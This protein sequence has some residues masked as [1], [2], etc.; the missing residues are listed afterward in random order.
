[1]AVDRSK[2]LSDVMERVLNGVNRPDETPHT[3]VI[4]LDLR[5]WLAGT[6]VTA[7]QLTVG[8][9]A[10]PERFGDRPARRSATTLKKRKRTGR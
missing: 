1:M 3:E 9:V 7:T 8:G 2:R 6:T 4:A 5:P 10:S